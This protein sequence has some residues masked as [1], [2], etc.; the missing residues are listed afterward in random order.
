MSKAHTSVINVLLVEIINRNM[1]DCV[2]ADSTSYL[3]K[4]SFPQGKENRYVIQRYNVFS[5]D[6]RMVA[7]ADL[8]VFPGGGVIKFKQEKFYYYISKI[9]ECAR[10][11]R[12]PVYFCSVGVES[13]DPQDE[14]CKM[15]RDA[16]RES[17]RQGIIKEITVR[18]DLRTL[19]TCYLEG[20]EVRCCSV[21]D[22][23]VYA[24]Q[25]YGITKKEDSSVIGIGVVRDQIFQDY[26]ISEISKEFQLRMWKDLT[27][28]LEARGYEWKLFVNGA[29][30]DYEFALELLTYLG[31]REEQQKYLAPRPA[32][33]RELVEIIASF[34]GIV[35]CRMHANIIAYSLGIPSVGLVWNNKLNFWGERI[36][37]PERFLSPACFTG[38]RIADCLQKS[39]QEGVVRSDQ[40]LNSSPYEPLRRFFCEY[41]E[42]IEKNKKRKFIFS[43]GWK[44]KLAATALGGLTYRYCD[45]NSPVTVES[46]LQNGFYYLETDVRMS[47]DEKLVCVNGWSEKTYEKLGLNPKQFDTSGLS[48]QDFMRCRYY[49]GHYPVTDLENLLSLLSGNQSWRLILDIGKPKK[50]AI[51]SY[52]SA[53]K[54]LFDKNKYLYKRCMIR[55]QTCHDVQVF[56]KVSHKMQLM[57]FYPNKETREKS[58]ITVSSVENFCKKQRIKWVSL[59]KSTFDRETAEEFRKT[60]LKTC[61]FTCKTMDEILDTEEKGADL[62]GSYYLTVNQMNQLTNR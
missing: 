18:D 22:P 56:R 23:A 11:Y 29:K 5:E 46:S 40:I 15:L 35:A 24:D 44:K 33:G 30:S 57:Y 9:L 61:V 2:I 19:Q 10:E 27:E 49:D 48:R 58:N 62:I 26:G 53:L 17:C 6:Y 37:Y 28:E 38:K 7:C 45:M 14:R 52:A 13:Y 3:L 59:A 4:K 50:A 43:A 60:H 54:C 16:L 55:V 1:G 34:Q 41:G 51:C 47:A 12:I 21:N 39:M 20:M 36:G 8:I 42:E 32:E 25:V 31:K